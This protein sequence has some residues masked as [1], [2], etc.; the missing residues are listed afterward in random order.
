MFQIS[1]S[2]C[3]EKE[4][5]EHLNTIINPYNNELPNIFKYEG[6]EII[7]IKY[8]CEYFNNFSNVGHKINE[9]FVNNDNN[10]LTNDNINIT[11]DNDFRSC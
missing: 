10:I 4:N 9:S 3:N 11:N 2:N 6:K 8:Q 5:C 7:N 1:F